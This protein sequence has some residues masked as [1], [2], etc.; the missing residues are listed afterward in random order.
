MDEWSDELMTTE[1]WLGLDRLGNGSRKATV[2]QA[3][4][5]TPLGWLQQLAEGCP[6]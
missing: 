1:L 5:V 6:W 4:V 3:S 2:V